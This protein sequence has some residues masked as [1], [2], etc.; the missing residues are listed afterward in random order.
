MR[1][2]AHT[3][4]LCSSDPEGVN[5]PLV[6]VDLRAPL[7]GNGTAGRITELG[8]LPLVSPCKEPADVFHTEGLDYDEQTGILRVG[9]IQW[10]PC[11]WVTTVWEFRRK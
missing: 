3:R 8:P 4:L 9:A 7:S 6:Q 2:Y 1:I 5:K 11:S 10:G